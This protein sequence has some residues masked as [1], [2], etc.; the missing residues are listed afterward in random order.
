MSKGK[1]NEN[2]SEKDTRS[3]YAIGY[4]WSVIVSSIGMEMALPPIFGI[5]LD[6]KFGTVMLFTLLG[7]AFGMITAMMHLIQ[8]GKKNNK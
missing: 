7:A 4:E 1:D 5:W 2:Q 6:Q 8:I 3:P